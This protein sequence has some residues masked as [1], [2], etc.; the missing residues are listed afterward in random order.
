MII[1]DKLAKKEIKSIFFD[2]DGTITQWID[3][4]LF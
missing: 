1:I 2:I 4:G 3:V